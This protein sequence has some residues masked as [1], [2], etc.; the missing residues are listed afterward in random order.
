M[1]KIM[2]KMNTMK[3]YSSILFVLSILL[4]N[5]TTNNKSCDFYKPV[6]VIDSLLKQN[7]KIFLLSEKQDILIQFNENGLIEDF[8]IINNINENQTTIVFDETTEMKQMML[9]K[10]TQFP[11]KYEYENGLSYAIVEYMPFSNNIVNQRCFVYSMINDSYS[12]YLSIRQKDYKTYDFFFNSHY[13]NEWDS[14]F[15]YLGTLDFNNDEA[16]IVEE[17]YE[18]IL[19]QNNKATI[20]SKEEYFEGGVKFVKVR[21]K[22]K[23][24]IFWLYF[25]YPNDFQNKILPI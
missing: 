14:V 6:I 7:N 12:T 13:E 2:K 4:I 22:T 10:K 3:K 16:N 18:K 15:I 21:S 8:N 25:R 9:H 5:C 20:Q 17:V 23:R 11:L 1:N 24:S 19:M